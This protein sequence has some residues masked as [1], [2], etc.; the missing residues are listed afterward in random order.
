MTKKKGVQVGIRKCSEL[1]AILLLA[2]LSAANLGAQ[3]IYATL[4]GV[5]SDPSGALVAQASVVLTDASSGSA[6]KSTTNNEG[7]FTF[8]SVPVGTFDLVVTAKGFEAYRVKGISLTGGE[9]RNVNANLTVGSTSVTVDISGA[10]DAVAPVDSG[11]KSA[12]LSTKE[13]ENFV[14]VGSN[15]AEFIKI[16]PGFGIQN[17]TSNKA[18][19]NGRSD[20]HQWQRRR[21]KP[22][23]AEQRLLLQWL[24]RQLARHHGGWR[25]RLRPGL[26]LRHACQSELGHDRRIQGSDLELQ[27]RKPEGSRGCQL[28]SRNRAASDFHGSGFFYARNYVLNANDW[29]NQC[30]SGE[31]APEQ[32]LL[33]RLHA[34][35]T[36]ADPRHEVQ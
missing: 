27:R 36:G 1:L 25:T 13:L 9:K 21:R 15:A 14:Q 17:G 8:A 11:E 32:V 34:R 22:E 6:R 31:P 7:Y 20:R 33:S 26:Q 29:L 35:R 28:P 18:N 16:M 30:Q 23:P 10:A 19:Y 3:G 24:A 12:T 2:A 5:V 4:T